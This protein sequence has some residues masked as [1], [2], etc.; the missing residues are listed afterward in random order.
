[1][2]FKRSE[3]TWTCKLAVHAAAYC[4]VRVRG[5][6]Q[7]FFQAA[8]VLVHAQGEVSV[9][10]VHGRHPFFDLASVAVAFLT[11]AVC[12]LDQQLHT[13]LGL[14]EGPERVLNSCTHTHINIIL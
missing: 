4:L 7:G 13:L 6:A 3:L 1:M 5:D 11:E 2:T 12:Q 14:L 10:L 9:A 8:A